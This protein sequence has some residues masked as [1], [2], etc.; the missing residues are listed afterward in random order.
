METVHDSR[1]N[2]AQE[3]GFVVR[4]ILQGTGASEVLSQDASLVGDIYYELNFLDF[5]IPVDIQ[6][7]PECATPEDT[8]DLGFPIPED[9]TN[10]VQLGGLI[11]FSTGMGVLEAGEFY[12]TEM[13][14]AGCT[15]VDES[16]GAEGLIL[17]FSGCPDGNA[18]IAI[19]P[20][21]GGSNVSIIPLP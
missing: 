5:D 15:G 4:L 10:I 20:E 11:S 12:K 18:Q 19:V 7:P 6:I 16:G 9:A 17:T 3:G 13:A 14:A 8:S 2:V 21:G 1:I